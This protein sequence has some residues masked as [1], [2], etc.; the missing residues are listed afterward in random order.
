MARRWLGVVVICAVFAVACGSDNGGGGSGTGGGDSGVEASAGSGG[1]GATGG[2]GATGGTG[3][4]GGS[5]ATGGTGATGGAAGVGGSGGA[6]GSATGGSGGNDGGVD[7]SA[8]SGGVGGTGGMAGSSGAGGNAGGSGN[9]GSAGAGGSSGTGGSGGAAGSGGTA[10]AGGTGGSAP[11]NTALPTVTGTA[12]VFETLSSTD[13]TWTPSTGLS[14]T[15]AW[16]RCN[17]GGT[18]CVTITGATASSYVLE[19]DDYGHRMRI[20]V[21]ADDGST[22]VSADSAA[23]GIVGAPVCASPITLGPLAAG[24]VSQVAATVPWS[25]PAQAT[26]DDGQVATAA[27]LLPGERTDELVVKGFGF[28][29]PPWALVTGV[30]LDVK[31]S[32]SGGPVKDLDVRFVAPKQG[33]YNMA[34]GTAWS[35]SSAVDSYGSPTTNLLQ[36][37]TAADIND[38]AF[39]LHLIA[40]N[41]GSTLATANVDSVKVTIYYTTGTA[42]GPKTPSVVSDDATIGTAAWPNPGNAAALDGTFADS[43]GLAA[44]EI[45]HGLAATG[46]GFSLPAGKQPS[47]IYVEVTRKAT[48]STSLIEDWGITVVKAGTPVGSGVNPGDI[49]SQTTETR[50]FGGPTS[51]FGT[52]L[53]AT[54]VEDSG[55]GFRLAARGHFASSVASV[56]SILMWVIYDS[57]ATSSAKYATTGSTTLLS[58]SWSNLADAAV[59]DGNSAYST[60]LAGDE[61]TNLLRSS[62]HGFAVP[63]D[64]WVRGIQLDVRRASSTGNAIEDS[65]VFL[66]LGGQPVLDNRA[67]AGKWPQALTTATYGSATD[68]WGQSVI[69]PSDVN[70]AAFGVDLAAKYGITAGNDTP[71]VDGMKLSVTYCAHP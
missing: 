7:A 65:M 42:I 23:T 37:F 28:A 6:D 8:G 15:R 68:L 60:N 56:D 43:P 11:V 71:D 46:Y 36:Y 48:G 13:G 35:A 69:Q 41:A 49:W 1:T 10:G 30:Q 66:R 32:A 57:T 67:L 64:A 22:Q 34:L 63:S 45:T 47:G 59:E 12:K 9:G 33:G 25:N 2:S 5:G 58:H 51:K 40:Q 27:S 50:S 55:F 31:R 38:P 62:A 70:A 26:A 44:F 17:V 18:G 52:T 61:V 29:L 20:R 4:T 53:T 14:F 16:L 24:S 54:D 19:R 21:T 39:A 3:A